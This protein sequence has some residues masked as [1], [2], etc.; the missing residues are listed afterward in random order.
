MLAQAKH[1]AQLAHGLTARICFRERPRTS[2]T[3]KRIASK[4]GLTHHKLTPSLEDLLTGDTMRLCVRVLRT[5][6]GM[7][8]RNSVVIAYALQV[9]KQIG[10]RRICTGDGAD[11]LFAGYSFMHKMEDT[12]LRKYTENMLRTMQ[13]CAFPLAK[14]LGIQGLVLRQAFPEVVSAA[15]VKEPIEGFIAQRISDGQFA[16]EAREA[17]EK[18]DIV[19]RDKE[20]LAYFRTFRAEVLGQMSR[21]GSDACPDCKFRT[22]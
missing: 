2:S 5:F 22:P 7:G 8:L 16:E 4:L 9:A 6:D 3:R 10:C 19:V 13:F 11:E 15:R 21:Y 14:E 12:D 20:R 1:R 17:L 18:Y